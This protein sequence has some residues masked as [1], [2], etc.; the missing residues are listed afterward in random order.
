[1]L[2]F[3]Q[4]MKRDRFT[5]ILRF[6][7][8]LNDSSLYRKKGEPGHDPLHKLQPF[9]EPR[10]AHFQVNYTL[11]KEVCI[12]ETMIGFKGILSFIQYIPKKPTKW[13]IK[14]FVLAD[15]QNGYM[16]NWHLYTGN[17]HHQFP[18]LFLYPL[19]LL[20]CT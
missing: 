18:M 3:L 16:Y 7:L 8:H 6:L 11:S 4:I 2:L 17:Y 20:Y 5:L 19:Q 15:S 10:V 1:M 13:G 9:M 14:A 12:D